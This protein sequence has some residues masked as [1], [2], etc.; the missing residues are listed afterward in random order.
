M[1]VSIEND[2]AISDSHVHIGQC[3]LSGLKLSVQ[4]FL[5]Y[6]NGNNLHQVVVMPF[7]TKLRETN[8][9]IVDLADC[10]QDV[11]GLMRFQITPYHQHI[12]EFLE[13][14]D[15]NKRVIGVKLHPTFDRLPITHPL[16]NEIVEGCAEREGLMLIHCGRW[17]EVSDYRFAYQIAAQYPQLKVIIA[18]MGGNELANCRGT[19]NMAQNHPNVYL[20]TS[21]CRLSLLLKEA[22]DLLGAHRI[23]FGTDYPWGS[24]HANFFTVYDAPISEKDKKTILHDSLEKLLESL[25]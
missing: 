8:S 24:F 17:K 23:L 9:K 1:N 4:N 21:N 14:L 19:I 22:V 25:K 2:W 7:D 18:H 16:F 5:E 12:K 20:D 6:I 13:L 10:F 15:R 3:G 11:Y